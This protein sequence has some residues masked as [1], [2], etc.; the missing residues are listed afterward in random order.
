MM[1]FFMKIV[2][3][4]LITNEKIAFLMTMLKDK[5]ALTKPLTIIA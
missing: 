4:F 5:K 3:S 1:D 2:N